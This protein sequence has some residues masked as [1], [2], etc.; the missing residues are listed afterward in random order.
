MGFVGLSDPNLE[1]SGLVTILSTE[2]VG[3]NLLNP[4]ARISNILTNFHVSRVFTMW[5]VKLL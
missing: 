1:D 3:F 2:K 4:W 5:V